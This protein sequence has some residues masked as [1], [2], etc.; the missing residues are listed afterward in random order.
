MKQKICKVIFSNAILL[1]ACL[2]SIFMMD[3]YNRRDLKLYEAHNWIAVEASYKDSKSYIYIDDD[4]NE[5]SCYKWYYEYEIDGQ[6][7]NYIVERQMN[8][9]PQDVNE[10]RTIMVAEDVNYL[11]IPYENE[12]DLK[13]TYQSKNKIMMLILCTIWSVIIFFKI[14]IDI[15]SLIKSA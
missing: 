8:E 9:K 5:E 6:V 7:Y 15:I 11:Y 13:S 10:T 2:I 1:A 4:Y 14:T 3:T 12:E